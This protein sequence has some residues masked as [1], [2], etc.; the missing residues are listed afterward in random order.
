LHH[1]RWHI[2]ILGKDEQDSCAKLIRTWATRRSADE[3]RV[4]IGS[5]RSDFG[6]LGVAAAARLRVRRQLHARLQRQRHVPVHAECRVERTAWQVP[7]QLGFQTQVEP[8]TRPIE[9]DRTALPHLN[10]GRE[11]QRRPST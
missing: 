2:E 10:A 3:I 11:P 9:V 1:A 8:H 6:L 5:G 4:C 7:A